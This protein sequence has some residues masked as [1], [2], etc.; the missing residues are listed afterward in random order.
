MH[1][2]YEDISARVGPITSTQI[3]NFVYNVDPD[4]TLSQSNARPFHLGIPSIAQDNK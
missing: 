1:V 3:A 2:I 4:M